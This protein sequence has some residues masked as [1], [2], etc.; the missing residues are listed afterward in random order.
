MREKKLDQTTQ[1]SQNKEIRPNLIEYY[2]V[3]EDNYNKYMWNEK[4]MSE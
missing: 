4:S 2:N 3:Q 1:H